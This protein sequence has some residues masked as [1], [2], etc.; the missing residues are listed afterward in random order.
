MIGRWLNRSGRRDDLVI[1]TKVRFPMGDVANR[2][3]LSA[4]WIRQEV[5]A[6]LRRLQTDH[7]DLYQ[8]HCL[9]TH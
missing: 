3:G 5:E 2:A 6:S 4:T 1:A 8:A 7:I 9:G